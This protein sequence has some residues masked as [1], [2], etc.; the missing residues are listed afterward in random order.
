LERRDAPVPYAIASRAPRETPKSGDYGQ[1]FGQGCGAGAAHG[2]WQLL[3]VFAFLQPQGFGFWQ[4]HVF[5]FWQPH[6]LAFWQPQGFDFWQGFGQQLLHAVSDRQTTAAARAENRRR[7]R[8]SWLW[9]PSP[10]GRNRRSGPPK[11]GEKIRKA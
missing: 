1:G 6:V 11:V 4:P 7:I 8:A 5:A 3:H 10:R 2:F 9:D